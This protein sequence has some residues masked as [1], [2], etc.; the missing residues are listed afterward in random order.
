MP[1][2]KSTPVKPTPAR[3]STATPVKPPRPSRRRTLPDGLRAPAHEGS[4]LPV[5]RAAFLKGLA[6]TGNVR[7]ACAGAQVSRSRAYEARTEQ[8]A[9][10]AAWEE[11]LAQ[12]ADALEAEAWRRAVEGER[13]YQFDRAGQPLRH[14]ETGAAYYELAKSDGLLTLLLK[15]HRP[16]RFKDRSAVETGPAP[17]P[18][19]DLSRLSPAELEQLE[20]LTRR[21]AG[22]DSA[23]TP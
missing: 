15:A 11:A 13:R 8:P 20:A 12:A 6:A 18:P 10:A 16:E 1:V 5:W 2:K 21:A 4:P 22:P 14:P 19:Y 3:T 7:E 17:A 23:P 9:F